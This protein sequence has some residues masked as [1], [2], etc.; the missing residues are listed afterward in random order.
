MDS[1]ESPL[2]ETEGAFFDADLEACEV[3]YSNV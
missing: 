2:W 1:H 3:T